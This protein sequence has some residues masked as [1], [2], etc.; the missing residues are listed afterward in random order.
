MLSII[1][2]TLN[3]AKNI[4]S[5]IRHFYNNAPIKQIEVIVSDGGSNDHTIKLA[6]EE[7]AKVVIAP[8]PGRAVQ[9]NFGASHAT[10]DILYF[11]HAD[12]VPPASFLYD[13]ET[14]IKNGFDFGRYIMKFDTK[15]WYLKVNAFFTRFDWFVCYGGDQTL[16]VTKKCFA[17]NGGFNDTMSIMEDYEFTKRLKSN[18]ANY[19]IIKKGVLI[20]DRKY[21]E[22]NWWKVQKANS[23]IVRMYKQGADQAAMVQKYKSMLRYR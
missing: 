6:A 17:E 23:T 18:G 9:M 8:K 1:I 11:V 4:G 2:P 20:S 21:D 12:V 16:F 14:S 5:L 19:C 15:K 7:G 22:N 10:G 13:I 3:E